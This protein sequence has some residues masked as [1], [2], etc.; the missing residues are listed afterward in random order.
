MLQI[1]PSNRGFLDLNIPENRESRWTAI[2]RPNEAPIL[3]L[4][5]LLEDAV[6]LNSPA[7]RRGD[8]R[9]LPRRFLRGATWGISDATEP[10]VANEL[11]PVRR[12]FLVLRS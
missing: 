12:F 4:G 2:D 6:R 10:N 7:K 3:R 1:T 5:V 9:T 11:G 8:G